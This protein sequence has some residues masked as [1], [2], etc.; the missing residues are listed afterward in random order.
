MLQQPW[1][2]NLFLRASSLKCFSLYTVCPKIRWYIIAHGLRM[3]VA[4]RCYNFKDDNSNLPGYI[5]PCCLTDNTRYLSLQ[6][7]ALDCIVLLTNFIYKLIYAVFQEHANLLCRR[8]LCLFVG[9]N[10]HQ[11]QLLTFIYW[12]QYH[13]EKGQVTCAISW[14]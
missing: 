14:G 5:C 9:V 4:L 13:S 1:M 11:I 8:Y 12:R 2:T 10:Q 3:E 6:Y 7:R